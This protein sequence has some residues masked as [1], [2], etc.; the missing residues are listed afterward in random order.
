MLRKV[1]TI[2]VLILNITAISV[3]A[4]SPIEWEIQADLK[5]FDGKVGV[6]ARNL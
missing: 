6:Y 1:I 5:Q 3:Y 4:A 2:L